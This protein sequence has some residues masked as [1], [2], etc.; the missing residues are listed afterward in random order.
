MCV[1][2][3]GVAGNCLVIWF[4]SFKIKRNSCTIYILNLAVADTIF[5]I[6][7]VVLFVI[8][9]ILTVRHPF[10]VS[11]EDVDFTYVFYTF[12]L[13]CLFGFN[14]S[15]CL[16]TVISVERCLSV[17]FPIWYRC[18]RHQHL[19]TIVCSA[20]WL[21]SCLFSVLEF[22][23]CYKQ[24]YSLQEH[25]MISG[26]V[27]FVIICCVTF[28]IFTPLMIVSS[29]IL[30]IKVWTTS[31]QQHAAKLYIVIAISVLFFLL[32]AIPMRILLLIWYKH[33]ITPPFP[34]LDIVSLFCSMNSTVNPFVY[35]LVGHRGGSRGKFSLLLIFQT[36]FHDE[37]S[38]CK[39]HQTIEIK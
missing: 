8:S 32:F 36:V 30:I 16:L 21:T 34:A 25:F 27:L 17:L 37:G 9:I 35:F 31:M 11:F 2:L 24:A 28:L 5:L 7:V 12:S 6:F 3:F 4:L 10:E 14:T 15:L 33:H 26:K 18:K 39:R 23:F 19:S 38:R 1:S 13:T 20:I 29:L 22:H